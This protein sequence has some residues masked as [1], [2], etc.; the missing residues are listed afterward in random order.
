MKR[1][2]TRA[3]PIIAVC[4]ALLTAFDCGGTQE[5]RQAV[6][7]GPRKIGVRGIVHKGVKTVE[8]PVTP[9]PGEQEKKEVAERLDTAGLMYTGKVVVDR[10]GKMLQPPETVAGF[11]G[12][13][14]IIAGEP[15][16]IE[17]AVIPAEPLFQV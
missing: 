2:M 17:F 16:E 1:N 8:A 11:A 3:L 6:Q 4:A 10:D 13:E 5:S 14:Y 15:P 9:S 7:S 12:K